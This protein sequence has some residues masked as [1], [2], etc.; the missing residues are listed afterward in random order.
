M[1]DVN[2]RS[3]S[4]YHKTG[5]ILNKLPKGIQPKAKQHIH[6]IWMAATR[7]AAVEAFDLFIEIYQDK[8]PKATDCLV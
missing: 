4:A 5:N 2:V 8:Y 1:I 7:E 6:D 3:S